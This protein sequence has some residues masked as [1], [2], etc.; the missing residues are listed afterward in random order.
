MP[1]T[2]TN[3]FGDVVSCPKVVV[4]AHTV[5][6]IVNVLTNP[7]QYP[8]PV[9]AVGSNHST[10]ACGTAERG[11][12]IR[13]KMNRILNVSADSLTVEAGAIH[14]DMAQALAK[15][16]RQFYI[17]TEIGNLTAG[18][19]ACC[20]TKDSSFPGEY[21]QVGSYVTGVRMVLPSGELLQVTDA[22]PD[23]MQKVRASYGSFG[24]VY[25]VTYRIR[26]ML[27]LSVHHKTFHLTEFTAQL[28]KLL[29]L[30]YAMMYYVF[31]FDDLITVEFRNYNPGAKDEP[32]KVIWPLRNYIWATS[33]PKF[34]HD[35]GKTISDPKI[36]YGVIDAFNALWRFK[37]EN[38]IT[39]DNTIPADEIIRYPDVAN[40]SRYTF[41]LYAFPE[42]QF[43][44]VLTDFFKFCRDYYASSGYRTDL[45][46]VGYRIG[47]DQQSLLSYSW[48]GPVMTI[49]PVSTANPGWEAF[50]DAYNQFCAERGGKPVMNQTAR[51]TPALAKQA[52]G[53]RLA[54]LEQTRKQY[55]PS[56]R[57]LNDFFRGILS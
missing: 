34:A 5:Q 54:L 3:W 29:A 23:L 24:I 17:N 49:D 46:D 42:Q 53:D 48:D 32:N 19:A 40:D 35:I 37:L 44:A 13:M 41:S 18:S 39:S 1:E 27:P 33:G 52:Y 2:V 55:D 22:Q 26:E 38:I 31:P 30:N 7:A 14:I 16:N 8:S 10:T 28:P 56:G 43:P 47:Q 21:G 12:L 9:R 15:Q 51:L 6:D 50:I 57:L 36:R 20:A 11:T 25:E 4:D 45:L